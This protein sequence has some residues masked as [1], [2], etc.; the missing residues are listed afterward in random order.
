MSN[1]RYLIIY[2]ESFYQLCKLLEREH[3][4][5]WSK[6]G[7]FLAHDQ[8]TF[9]EMMNKELD[10]SCA[11]WQEID[12]VCLKYIAALKFRKG[13]PATKSVE[14]IDAE[15]T[16][17]FG[18]EAIFGNEEDYNAGSELAIWKNKNPGRS[19]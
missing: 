19:H 2:P 12:V 1:E 8:A 4:D 14:L 11:T 6:V 10:C 16:G 13:R 15:R 3:E 5:L 9:I 17:K 7:Y 18:V